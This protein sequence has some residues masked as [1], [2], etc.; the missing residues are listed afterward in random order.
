MG[1]VMFTWL[2]CSVLDYLPMYDFQSFNYMGFYSN[3]YCL[4]RILVHHGLMNESHYHGLILHQANDL[5]ISLKA[6][7]ALLRILN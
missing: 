1:S 2:H 6:I 7:Y 3:Y 4:V 5:L